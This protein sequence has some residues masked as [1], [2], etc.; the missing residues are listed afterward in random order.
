MWRQLKVSLTVLL[1]KRYTIYIDHGNYNIYDELGGETWLNNLEAGERCGIVLPDYVDLIGYNGLATLEMFIP[2]DL[3]T[4]ENSKKISTL[5]IWKHNK[6]KN[7]IVKATNC[8]YALHIETNNYFSDTNIVVENCEFYHLGATKEGLWT[9]RQGIA[10]GTGSGGYYKF[11]NCYMFSRDTQPF[12]IHNNLYQYTN[13]VIF[14]GCH[15]GRGEGNNNADMCF[16]TLPSTQIGSEKDVAI[17]KS[18]I[19]NRIDIDTNNIWQVCDYVNGT[20]TDPNI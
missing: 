1:K 19:F 5:N 9:S 16:Y 7:L 17:V 2:N 8:R 11:V 3:A 20:I 6:L 15:F 10:C 14:D 13:T 4:L 18:C 12:T